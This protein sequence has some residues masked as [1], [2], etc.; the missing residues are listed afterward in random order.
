MAYRFFF[1]AAEAAV[2]V[3]RAEGARRVLVSFAAVRKNPKLLERFEGLEVFLDSGAWSVFTGGIPPIDVDEFIAWHKAARFP[4]ALRAGLDVIGDGP[5]SFD[6]WRR[7]VD[8]GL[9]VFPT[10]HAGEPLDL[11]ARYA[12][13]APFLAVGGLAG[14]NARGV[15]GDVVARAG[16][17]VDL[18]RCHLFG[19][20]LGPV[21]IRNRAASSDATSWINGVQYGNVCV[22]TVSGVRQISVGAL[23]HRYSVKLSLKHASTFHRLG[24]T[25][26]ELRDSKEARERFNIRAFLDFERTLNAG[27]AR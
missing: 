15:V 26:R 18:R 7:C 3:L 1:A 14:R 4:F 20:S 22:P 8:A 23:D 5:K 2:D 24:F 16:T 19:V 17:V 6:N 25:T 27:A 13:G 9:D 11:L 10:W 21:V 12:E